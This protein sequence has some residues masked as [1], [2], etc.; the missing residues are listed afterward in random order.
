METV[1]KDTIPKMV[2]VEWE[3]SSQPRSSWVFISDL[4][5]PQIIKCMS[6]G[7][8]LDDGRDVKTLALSIGHYDDIDSRQVNGIMTIPTRC[9]I[10][11][12]NL[13]T[14]KRKE[15]KMSP[16]KSRKKSK[17]PK[18]IKIL[19]KETSDRVSSFASAG[20]K[21]PEKLTPKQVRSI[22]ASAM[23]Q[24]ETKGKRSKKKKR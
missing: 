12:D 4:D 20:V 22:S 10:R 17:S 24:D 1:K 6:V 16:N 19:K 21:D 23:S 8:L 15:H 2:L 14:S 3:D 18:K 5:E 13:L 7:Y 11:I 9:I